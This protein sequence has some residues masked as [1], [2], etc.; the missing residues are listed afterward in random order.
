MLRVLVL[1]VLLLGAVLA[2]SQF[3]PFEK[4]GNRCKSYR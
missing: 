3:C 2:E 1:G 4:K